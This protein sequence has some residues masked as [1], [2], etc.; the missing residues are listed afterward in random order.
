MAIVN[1]YVKQG[2]VIDT[3]VDEA[4]THLLGEELMNNSEKVTV[5]SEI[6]RSHEHTD[7]HTNV[8]I[9]YLVDKEFKEGDL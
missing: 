6:D 3:V 8:Y 1:I 5:I 4:T 2:R 9:N 7:Y